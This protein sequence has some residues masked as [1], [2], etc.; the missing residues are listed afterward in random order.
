LTKYPV[1]E[2]PSDVFL[3]RI[4]NGQ[5]QISFDHKGVLPSGIRAFKTTFSKVLIKSELLIGPKGGIRQPLQCTLRPVA[6][7]FISLLV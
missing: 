2:L 5:S 7:F 6:P 4:G 3:M 1:Q